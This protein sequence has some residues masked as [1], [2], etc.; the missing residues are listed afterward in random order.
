M[1][2][3]IGP[4]QV[5]DDGRPAR[6]QAWLVSPPHRDPVN[7]TFRARTRQ[8]YGHMPGMF[9]FAD[10]CRQPISRLI[11]RRSRSDSP[12]QMPN[13]S[14]FSSAYSRHSARTSQVRQTRLASRVEPPFSGKNASGSVCAQSA[15]S[16]QP[17][18]SMSSGR[19]S[20]C[21]SGTMT[22]VTAHPPSRSPLTLSAI[23]VAGENHTNEITPACLA[24]S[25]ARKVVLAPWLSRM[26]SKS[27]QK[28][29]L[30]AWLIAIRDRNRGATGR[31]H[32]R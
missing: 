31:P 29:S 21:V 20:T 18:S 16:C 3:T 4:A 25:Q 28:T 2:L 11:R 12:P 6:R 13:R 1:W 23:P 22:S 9:A 17:R 30:R 24:L 14:S 8:D 5:G 26:R 32:R 7:N 10:P 19:T 27:R 15:R